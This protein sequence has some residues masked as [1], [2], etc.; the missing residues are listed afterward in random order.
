MDDPT[1]QGPASEGFSLEQAATFVLPL[2][3]WK[4]TLARRVWLC[5]LWGLKAGLILISFVAIP[6]LILSVFALAAG[7][8]PVWNPGYG[9]GVL[10]VAACVVTM[11][12]YVG[13]PIGLIERL[14]PARLYAATRNLGNRPLGRFPRILSKP[15]VSVVRFF[16]CRWRW[17]L[18]IPL[19]IAL[20]LANAAGVYVRIQINSRYRAALALAKR[21]TPFW[22]GQA[23]LDHRVPVPEGENSAL[24]VAAAAERL[25]EQWPPPAPAT[26]STPN[27]PPSLEIQAYT[28]MYDAAANLPLHENVVAILRQ[29]LLAYEEAVSIGRTLRNYARGRNDVEVELV[30]DPL[31][32]VSPLARSTRNVARLLCADAAV[33]AEDG[34]LDA[35]LGSCRAILG[36][37]RSIGDEPYTLSQFIH[38]AIASVA[39]HL[40]CRVLGQ[41][42][43]SDAALARLQED[44]LRELHQPLLLHSLRGHGP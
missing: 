24:V 39:I 26:P 32:T 42:Q 16:R 14:M 43:P 4:N 27:P 25:P 15:I 22:S 2:R 11:G 20:I 8:A 9:K 3:T 35:A 19:A 18:G 7:Y 41:G 31:E 36:A 6:I 34:D 5:A 44:A 38:H 30:T 23:F 29:Q 21:D 28:L 10:F 13:L 37:A 12:L 1:T 33:L 17:I 40:T